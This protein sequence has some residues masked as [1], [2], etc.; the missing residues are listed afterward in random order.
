M[1][2]LTLFVLFF[3]FGLQAQVDLNM[4]L[5]TRIDAFEGAN[6]CWGFRHTNGIEYVILGTQTSTK[7]YSLQVPTFPLEKA[8][9]PGLPTV[10]RDIKN[11]GNYAYVTAD[12]VNE[13]L[14]ILDINDPN[15]IVAKK[16]T[17][18]LWIGNT[19]DT[20]EYCHNLYIDDE[21]FGY[22]AGCNISNQGVIII[23][24]ATDPMEPSMVGYADLTYSHDVYVDGDTMYSSEINNGWL[25]IYDISDKTNPIRIATQETG[26][27]FTHNAWASDDQSLVFT[28]D[29]KPD[30]FLEA[31]DISDLSDI[32]K[33]D[34]YRP[35]V[36]E[37]RGVIPHN[38]H[39]HEGFLYTSWY[40]D[41]IVVVDA[42]RPDNLV[43]VAGYDTWLGPDGD[44]N[45]CW[46]AF[47]FLPSGL[48]LA[49]DRS[50]GLHVFQPSFDRACYLEGK[51][52][53]ALTGLPIVG[54][55]VTIASPQQLARANSDPGGNYKTG[56]ANSG[57]YD[58]IVSHPFY[59]ELLTT[60]ELVNGEVTILDVQ[61]VKPGASIYTGT[62]IKSADGQFVPDAMVKLI[63]PDGA[64]EEFTSDDA[65]NVIFELQ[66]GVYD[67]YAG[68][69]GYKIGHFQFDTATDPLINIPL[70]V[71]YRDEFFFDYEW[72]YFGGIDEG[73]FVVG[74]PD[75][76][77]LN[78]HLINIGYDNQEDIGTRAL[79][80][81]DG[82]NHPLHLDYVKEGSTIAISPVMDLSD[83]DYPVINFDLFFRHDGYF[84]PGMYSLDVFVRRG[85]DHRLITQFTQS[86]TMWNTIQIHPKQVF[87]DL[88]DI[89][90][91][92][93]IFNDV[94]GIF[95]EV[96]IDV[97]EVVE[98][99]P[100][101]VE[102]FVDTELLIYPNPSSDEFTISQ[103]SFDYDQYTLRD[104]T[105]RIVSSRQ[106]FDRVFEIDAS[107]I[108]PGVY[109]LQMENKNKT[110]NTYKLVKQ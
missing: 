55:T 18:P 88:T 24:L 51:V 50:T 64:V 52:T 86:D 97:F 65:G 22:L 56:V 21:G 48:I 9:I 7:V 80:T 103:E 3:S 102:E 39:Y 67:I 19:I 14:T 93:S 1:R 68:K 17:P 23:D 81:G 106:I 108:E 38:T 94:D 26:T 83:Y 95:T 45:G 89:E 30:A 72:R 105:G 6:D 5:V 61:L 75:T 12:K 92:F 104:I 40:T 57:T 99:M 107:M 62:T 77:V 15:N 34:A 66:E 28:T 44:F 2:Y 91:S 32:E 109:F 79:L 35:P 70:E 60:A 63:Y 11:F 13:G 84:D 29:E 33:L 110:S 20:L 85:S 4:E 87:W 42:H 43:K 74:E 49:S 101:A 71:G 25:G 76:L 73:Y 31:Y 78:N 82:T 90:V 37:G 59:E 41:G 96:A 46:G 10:W 69:W 47:P 98:G 16:W 53:S 54:A 8:V 27:S 58:V 100:S 36:T